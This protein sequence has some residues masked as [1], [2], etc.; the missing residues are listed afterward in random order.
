MF[1][2]KKTFDREIIE[3]AKEN[4]DKITILVL[5]FEKKP[6]LPTDLF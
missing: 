3:I 5:E 6:Q 1:S 2:Q 4:E